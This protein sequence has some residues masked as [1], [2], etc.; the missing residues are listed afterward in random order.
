M[1]ALTVFEDDLEVWARSAKAAKLGDCLPEVREDAPANVNGDQEERLSR[2]AQD[3]A[4]L[5]SLRGWSAER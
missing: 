2:V 1:F 5:L 4:A 3:F